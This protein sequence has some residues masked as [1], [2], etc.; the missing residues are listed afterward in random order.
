MF[1]TWSTGRALTRDL[2]VISVFEDARLPRD[3]VVIDP[4][5]GG[6]GCLADSTI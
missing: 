4:V 5:Q 6:D 3:L 1:I 2:K